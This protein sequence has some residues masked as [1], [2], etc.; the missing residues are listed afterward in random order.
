MRPAL[1]IALVVFAILLVV[2]VFLPFVTRVR[3]AAA[4]I[5]CSNNLKSIAIAVHNYV[6]TYGKFPPGT[7]PSPILPLEKRL[8]WIFEVLPFM[9]SD[10]TYSSAKKDLA[11]DAPANLQLWEDWKCFMCPSGPAQQAAYSSRLTHYV[12]IAG[13]GEDAA[14]YSNG[15]ARIGIFGYDRQVAKKDVTDG[16]SFTLMIMETSRENGP[17]A[18]GGRATIRGIDPTDEP[19]IGPRRQFGGMHRDSSS[20]FGRSLPA[21]NCI[22]ADGSLR[23]IRADVDPRVLDKAATIAGAEGWGGDW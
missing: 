13:L 9:G 6:D 1:K 8:S 11:W 10:P 19:Y 17:W 7:R 20:F 3:D 23:T 16:L 18:A 12:G 22:M 4:R 2:G 21:S 15:D 14:T 5:Q